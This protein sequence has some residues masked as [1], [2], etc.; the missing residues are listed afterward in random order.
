VKTKIRLIRE[1]EGSF[2][3]N[4]A[5]EEVLFQVF[6]CKLYLSGE[7]EIC[8]FLEL[9]LEKFLWYQRTILPGK[10]S[11]SAKGNLWPVLNRRVCR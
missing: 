4:S 11:S 9:H 8:L 7:R 1:S 2:Y 5:A 10:Y 6:R 3:G